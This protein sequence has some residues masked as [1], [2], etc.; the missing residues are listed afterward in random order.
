M[1]TLDKKY[2]VTGNNGGILIELESYKTMNECIE[3]LKTNAMGSKEYAIIEIG[4]FYFPEIKRDI[5]VEI[6]GDER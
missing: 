5:K 4:K 2:M 1:I 3:Y 6:K